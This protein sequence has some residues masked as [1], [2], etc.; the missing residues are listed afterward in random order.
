MPGAPVPDSLRKLLLEH[1]SAHAPHYPPSNN[2]DH[3]P[4]TYLAMHGLG[5]E[6]DAIARFAARYRR[7]L[8]PLAS[9]ELGVSGADWA[10]QLG[11]AES[12]PALLCFF[13][14]EV[15]ANGWRATVARYLPALISGWVKDAF[16]PLIRLG[17]GIEFE[18][19]SEVAAGLAYLTASGD[20]PRLARA[21]ER[22]P[23]QL[24]GRAYLE[25]VR[26]E[27]KAHFA[28]GPFNA[29]YGRILDTVPLQPGTRGSDWGASAAALSRACL[30]VFHATHDFFALHLVTGSHAF[31]LC[32]PFAGANAGALFDVGI[33]AAYLA[34]GAPVFR[35][36]ESAEGELPLHQLAAT[37]DEH[38]LKI[39]YTCRAQAQAYADPTYLWAAH[40]YL[41]SRPV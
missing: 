39:G 37:T 8:A 24:E 17:Y 35:E 7:K 27:R 9:V 28:E 6:S 32:V 3:G 36:L 4:M 26:A 13:D 11:R 1:R 22:G 33:G 16:H 25:A 18:V 29:R 21:K 15:A 23:A 2:S 31:R 30:E 19:P 38:D 20:D 12:Y 40:A 41:S 5:F 10:E 34:I 14:A